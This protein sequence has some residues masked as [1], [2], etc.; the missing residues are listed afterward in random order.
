MS[1]TVIVLW[2]AI[3]FDVLKFHFVSML[4]SLIQWTLRSIRISR[5]RSYW[6]L[7]FLNLQRSKLYLHIFLYHLGESSGRTRS[8][9]EIFER[10]PIS[11]PFPNL[12]GVWF[13]R[14]C[15][16]YNKTDVSDAQTH[17]LLLIFLHLLMLWRQIWVQEQLH[18]Y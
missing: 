6:M 1:V 8:N 7:I 10:R 2:L 4:S 18:T 12:I 17:N 3:E 9:M 15:Q 11:L 14:S 5:T 16:P 13:R